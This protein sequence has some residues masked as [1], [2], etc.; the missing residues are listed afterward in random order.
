VV[1]DLGAG[2]EW[3]KTTFDLEGATFNVEGAN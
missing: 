1:S 2:R 3:A